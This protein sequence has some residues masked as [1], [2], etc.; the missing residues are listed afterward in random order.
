VRWPTSNNHPDFALALEWAIH[1][2][3]VFK[4]P[5]KP[6]LFSLRGYQHCGSA[7]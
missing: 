7:R 1:S 6:R 4:D 2:I 5:L 3:G